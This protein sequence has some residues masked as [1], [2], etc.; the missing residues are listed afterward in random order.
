M[1]SSNTARRT[2]SM[3][4][5]V[6]FLVTGGSGLILFFIH[7]GHG[8]GGHHSSFS[9]K[10]IHEMASLLFIIFALIHAGLNWK[11]LVK[12]FRK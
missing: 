6:L 10:H 3:W 11:V 12:Y 9:V 1:S 8:S 7:G 2:V 4:T 5:A